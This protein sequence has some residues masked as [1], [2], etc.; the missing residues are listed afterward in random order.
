MSYN[1][2]YVDPWV[3]EELRQQT[4][5]KRQEGDILKLKYVKNATILPMQFNTDCILGGVV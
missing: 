5:F 3:K 2:D 1:F 4:L